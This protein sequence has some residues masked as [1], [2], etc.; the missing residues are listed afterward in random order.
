MNKIKRLNLREL[1][2]SPGKS[3]PPKLKKIEILLKKNPL[4]FKGNHEKSML[5]FKVKEDREKDKF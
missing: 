1:S 2:P 5:T 4:K 3:L